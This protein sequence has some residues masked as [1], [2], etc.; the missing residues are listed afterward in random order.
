MVDKKKTSLIGL[1]AL[2]R[3]RERVSP[4]LRKTPFIVSSQT[5]ETP[6]FSGIFSLKLE[7]MQV[8]GSFKPRGAL[9][10]FFSTREDHSSRGLVAASGGNH[11]L[12]VAYVGSL[13]RLKTT[14][15][16]PKNTP[17]L[18]R[19]K[20]SRWGAKIVEAGNNI[21]EAIDC[22]QEAADRK[23]RLYIHPFADE[24]IIEG[25]GTLGLDILEDASSLKKPI[26][27][28]VVAIGGGGLIGG[29]GSAF[30]HLSPHTR[31]IGVEPECCPTMS[32]ALEKGKPCPLPQCKTIAGTLSVHQTSELNFHLAQQ[33]VDDI[34][35]V[36][37]DELR[38]GVKWLWFEHAIGA[39]F[40]G[41]AAVAALLSGKIQPQKGTHTCALVC[42]AGDDILVEAAK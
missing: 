18:K 1:K 36:T 21:S 37:D 28:L 31:I 26:D 15:Y 40:S 33:V 16:L 38:H 2:Q 32:Y 27:I 5:Q 6:D 12:A 17:Q 30:R 13:F 35:L 20:I 10:K 19:E 23:E 3:A 34:V 29:V 25:Q 42:G 11:G 7:H 39:E 8:T 22:A 41:A 4:Y 14:I 24:R 9:N